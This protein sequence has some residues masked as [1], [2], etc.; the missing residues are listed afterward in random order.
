MRKLF[1]AVPMLL[2]CLTSAAFGVSTCPPASSGG[3]NPSYASFN[4]QTVVH[5]ALITYTGGV[6]ASEA[7]I[8]YSGKAYAFA[9]GQEIF[10]QNEG[11]EVLEGAHR[12]LSARSANI[13]LVSTLFYDNVAFSA[14]SGYIDIANTSSLAM[15]VNNAATVDGQTTGDVSCM[16]G[17]PTPHTVTNSVTVN[18]TTTT[19]NQA[20][21]LTYSTVTLTVPAFLVDKISYI[22]M[23]SEVNCPAMG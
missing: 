9:V 11:N 8:Q 21:P 1:L 7:E 2:L 13:I 22:E 20:I 23:A 5:T 17:A 12:V 6:T 19:Q 3:P 15:T 4:T 16:G 18:G 10:V 14:D